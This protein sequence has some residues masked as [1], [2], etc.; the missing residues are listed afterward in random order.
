[1]VAAIARLFILLGLVIAYAQGALVSTYQCAGVN[2]YNFKLAPFVI[3]VA[4]DE[5]AEI[6]KFFINSKVYDSSS[7]SSEG[8]IINDVNTTTNKY[9]TF[10]VDIKFMGKTFIN[11]DVRFC[12]MLAVKHT[13]DYLSSPRNT[14][15]IE[16]NL[17]AYSGAMAS[18]DLNKDASHS[19]NDETYSLATSNKTIES[20][21]DNSTGSLVQC[22]LYANDS[23]VMYYEVDISDHYL[24]LGS[25]TVNFY[26]FANDVSSEL[27]GCNRAYVTPEHSN[28]VKA[29]LSIGVPVLL[30][31]T[32]LINFFTVIYSSHQESSNPF[33]FVA[34]TICNENLLKQLDA[35]VEEI[36]TYL[37]FA[38]FIGGLDLQYPGFYQ[39][40]V[41]QIRW[42]AL[43]G[44]AFIRNGKSRHTE[45]DNIYVTL[46]LDG[47]KNLA[48]YSNDLS[49]YDCWPNFILALVIW[50][51][52]M[53]VAHQLFLI[54]RMSFSWFYNRKRKN[55]GTR[56]HQEYLFS[57]SNNLDYEFTM[58][59]NL[60]HILGQVL[61]NFFT[62]FGFPFLVLTSFMLYNA[63]TVGGKYK[64]FA[65]ESNLRS[66]IFSASVP[67]D[68][69]FSRNLIINTSDEMGSDS[70][71]LTGNSLN[72]TTQNFAPN[73]TGVVKSS[74]NYIKMRIG[75][76]IVG[77]ILV[78][79]WVGLALFFVFNYLITVNNWRICINKK[80]S[81]LYTS[82]KSILMWGF[83]YCK[84][85][86]DKVY[87]VIIDLLMLFIK[88]LIIG[89]LQSYGTV[90]VSLL[91]VIE[92]IGLALLFVL[93]P[94]FVK[95]TWTTSRWIL[96]VARLLVTCLCIPYIRHLNLSESTRTY[97]SFVQ[98][99]VHV[100]V[101]IV[102]TI[103]LLYCLI[104]TVLSILRKRRDK[105]QYEKCV[106][107]CKPYNSVEE[108]NTQFEYHPVVNSIP[109]LLHESECNI[110]NKCGYTQQIQKNK[111]EETENDIEEEDPYYRTRSEKQLQ[112]IHDQIHR[113]SRAK[114]PFIRDHGDFVLGDDLESI[115]DSMLHSTTQS[116]LSFQQQQQ[117][118]NLR[119]RK[120]DYTFREGDLIYKKYFVDD[121]IDP[122]IK[123][124]WASRNNWNFLNSHQPH[125]DSKKDIRQ[126]DDD[127]ILR[128]HNEASEHHYGDHLTCRI[129]KL[130]PF[131]PFGGKKPDENSFQVSRPRPL[132]VKPY[133]YSP[134]ED[135]DSTKNFDQFSSF[136]SPSTSTLQNNKNITYN[137]HDDAYKQEI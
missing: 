115:Q 36:I 60:Y 136:S 71:S 67:Y 54:L 78:A 131:K 64:Y 129:K 116:I 125:S 2:R 24:K 98:L 56:N 4:L 35:T 23:I 102:F 110:P 119:K 96:P 29:T 53:I 28:D 15:E 49:F 109:L 121:S 137:N 38:L 14:E 5:E 7:M 1:M 105:V 82:M 13:E 45:L 117:Y 47:L 92:F 69:I 122:E 86:P 113:T 48:T 65:N 108:F 10:H 3:D 81:H 75:S 73:S 17:V 101:A 26:V 84:Y 18:K 128:R 106:G 132:T 95:M 44:F 61:K 76:M 70:N 127:N 114:S 103:H 19:G 21:F 66:N 50:T 120:N 43:M 93:K 100:F 133:G 104:I 51:L 118:S 52:I 97:V 25:Y 88:L 39:P 83:C 12:D 40:L 112:N 124:L 77:S 57:S 126:K 135:R 22:P 16:N 20:F 42:C 123:A 107:N 9:T 80:V 79:L 8:V 30:V 89:C 111:I 11:E 59:K 27:I 37:Q 134:E 32:G 99:S 91:I 87:F 90:Q 34:S 63:G 31:V 62:M 85:H 130:F 58:K 6:L 46:N 41:G 33:L 55:R 72:F 74:E 94:Y 68:K